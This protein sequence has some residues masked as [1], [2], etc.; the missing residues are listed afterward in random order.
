MRGSELL[1][2]RKGLEMKV[3]REIEKTIGCGLV[4]V[5]M[6]GMDSP[7]LLYPVALMVAGVAVARLGLKP[8]KGLHFE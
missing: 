1:T 8:V 2:R 5:G 4:L 3:V 6:C 7:N